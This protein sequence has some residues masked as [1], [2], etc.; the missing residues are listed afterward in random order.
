MATSKKNSK[1]QREQAEAAK[2]LDDLIA[3]WRNNSP[4]AWHRISFDEAVHLAAVPRYNHGEHPS[5]TR[6]RVKGRIKTGLKQ[7]K[8]QRDDDGNFV[9][10]EFVTWA[11]SLSGW[12][13]TLEGFPATN[14]GY[15]EIVLPEFAVSGYS[16]R[17]ARC[18]EDKQYVRDNCEEIW[19]LRQ[20]VE[21]LRRQA[22]SGRRAKVA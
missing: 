11:R 5:T 21:A 20:E 9:L 15:A 10:G 2:V 3:T 4:P 19:R 17:E 7:R 16:Y 22:I 12:G 13:L 6:N 8:L 1:K 18:E 14:S